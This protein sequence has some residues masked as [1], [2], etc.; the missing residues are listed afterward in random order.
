[1]PAT[2]PDYSWAST[3]PADADLDGIGPRILGVVRRERDR[4]ARAFRRGGLDD[5]RLIKAIL[6]DADEPVVCK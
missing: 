5:A 1:M 3:P 4:V 2:R 6:D